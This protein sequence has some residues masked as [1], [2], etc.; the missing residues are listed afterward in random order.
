MLLALGEAE[1][2]PLLEEHGKVD[3]TCEFCG[4]NYSY[5]TLQVRELFAAEQTLPAANTKLN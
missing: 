3:V 2:Q 4:R 1:I 5:D